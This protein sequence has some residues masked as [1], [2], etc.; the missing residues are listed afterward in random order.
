MGRA[1][2]RV[3]L[4]VEIKLPG[5]YPVL[6][7]RPPP[8]HSLFCHSVFRYEYYFGSRA[9]DEKL[10]LRKHK[11]L[12]KVKKFSKFIETKVRTREGSQVR[13]YPKARFRTARGQG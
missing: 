1:I 2:L 13:V 7:L 10:G 3:L 5:P 9:E 6:F 8:P 11:Q 12:L 4:P